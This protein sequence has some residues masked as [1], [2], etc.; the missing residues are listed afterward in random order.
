MIKISNKFDLEKE[1]VSEVW[2]KKPLDKDVIFFK[3]KKFK[4]FA[5]ITLK[6]FFLF[7]IL[8]VIIQ[9]K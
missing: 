6:F 5:S 3:L 8:N 2:S 1:N 9:T 7:K 4:F